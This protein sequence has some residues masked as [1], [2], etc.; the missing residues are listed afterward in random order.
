MSLQTQKIY[1]NKLFQT[2]G[3]LYK[4]NAFFFIKPMFKEI[5]KSLE[6]HP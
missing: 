5:A 2:L 4:I 6:W 3:E 1:V